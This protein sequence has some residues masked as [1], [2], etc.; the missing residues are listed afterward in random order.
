MKINPFNAMQ[1]QTKR[2]K[3]R[4]AWQGVTA[5][6]LLVLLAK[7]HLPLWMDWKP[8]PI[9]ATRFP[10]YISYS[11]TVPQSA[12]LLT[13]SRWPF[14]E[15]A[16]QGPEGSL[17]LRTSIAILSCTSIWQKSTGTFQLTKFLSIW[18]PLKL[19]W[20]PSI[21]EVRINFCQSDMSSKIIMEVHCFLHSSNFAVQALR[22]VALRPSSILA[23]FS[24]HPDF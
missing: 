8:C 20:N 16:G 3:I 18:F 9:L 22:V 23:F 11:G 7:K 6:Y 10:K 24:L 19:T 13:C 21:L 1:I 4:W 2:F 5:F 17:W 15:I 14:A 12:R